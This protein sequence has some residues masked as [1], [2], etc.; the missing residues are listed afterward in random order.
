MNSKSEGHA[1][2]KP[3]SHGSEKA[4]WRRKSISLPIVLADWVE[5]RS[6]AGGT[7]AYIASLIEADRHAQ[8]VRDELSAFG[9]TDQMAITDA[10][11]SRARQ[12]LER[13]AA[14]RASRSRQEAA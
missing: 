9:Y 6:A 11:R 1:S 12:V 13:Q 4:T 8:L 14:S 5:A 7:S 10:G 2:D 3:A